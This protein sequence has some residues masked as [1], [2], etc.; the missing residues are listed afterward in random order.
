M[1]QAQDKMRAEF[2]VF[3]SNNG[4]ILNR[5]AA[6]RGISEKYWSDS[7]QKAWAIWQAACAQQTS[8]SQQDALDAARYRWLARKVGAHGVIDGWE[9]SF[10][11]H[12]TIPAPPIAMYDPERALGESIDALIATQGASNV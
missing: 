6:H 9:F 4:M 3:A 8:Q 7:T 5:A 10:P 11:T 2:E 12:L 1:T